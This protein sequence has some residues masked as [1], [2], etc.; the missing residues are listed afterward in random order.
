MEKKQ[1]THIETIAVHAA[2]NSYTTSKDVV[3][4]IQLSTSF[5]RNGDGSTGEFVYNRLDNPNRKMLQ[6]KLAALEGSGH[7]IVFASGLAAANAIL[8]E[9]LSPG[10]HIILPIDCYHG[11]KQIVQQFFT[12]WQVEHSFVNMQ[13]ID[14]L[15]ASIKNNTS[16]IWMETPSNPILSITDIAAVIALAKAK[17]I[18]TVCD[19][20]FATPIAQRPLY[21]GVDVVMHSSTKYF[22]GHSDVLGGVLCVNNSILAERLIAYQKI[23]GAVPSP[24]DCWLINRSLATFPLRYKAQCQNATQIAGYLQKHPKIEAVYFP[25]LADHPQHSIAKKQMNG[26]YG[27]MIAILIK[28]NQQIAMQFASALKVFKHATSL[29]AVESLVE[30][31]RSIEGENAVSPENLL[32]LSI[33]VE[34]HQDLINDLEQAFAKI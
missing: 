14:E 17:N 30:H 12:K 26:F 16:V 20:T 5:E 19:N 8:Q 24:F 33:G 22:A 23:A 25:G 11:V 27:A 10:S 9:L 1:Q 15:A 18:T 2:N 28:G 3:P 4:A 13:K 31:R 21:L 7:A 6:E 29:G 34:H 32:R